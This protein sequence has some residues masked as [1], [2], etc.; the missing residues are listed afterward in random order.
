MSFF[1]GIGTAPWIVQ[2]LV[3]TPRLAFAWEV[4]ADCVAV[5][6]V[7][8]PFVRHRGDA[9][10]DDYTELAELI[11]DEA[12][13]DSLFILV[14]SG[15]P[16][17]DFSQVQNRKEGRLGEE[18][19][20]FS[21][22]CKILQGLEA[23]LGR[24]TFF[25]LAENVVMADDSDTKYFSEALQSQ[26]VL[27]DAADA[28]LISRPRLWWTRVDWSKAKM[29]P[30]T[31]Q[32]LQWTQHNQHRRLRL[33]LPATDTT[34]WD[35]DGHAL[36]T[37]VLQH[38]RRVPCLTTPAPDEHGRA[39]P[40][41]SHGRVDHDTRQRWLQHNRQ[42]APWQYAE[43][44]MAL[45]NDQLVPMPALLKEQLH[46]YPAH[47]T[48]VSKVTNKA[49]HRTLANSWHV[50]VG[51]FIMALVLQV[52]PVHAHPAAGMLT[53]SSAIHQ[54][55]SLGCPAMAVVGPGQWPSPGTAFH[56][57]TTMMEHWTTAL[58]TPHPAQTAGKLEPGLEATLCRH[59]THWQDLQLLRQEVVGEVRCMVDAW[60]PTTQHWFR[61]LPPEIQGVYSANGTKLV[62]Q[63]PLL[64]H[65]LRICGFEGV[66]ELEEDLTCGFPMVGQLHSGSGWLPRRDGQYSHP[67]S[68]SQFHE[69]NRAYVKEKIRQ[70]KHSPHWK[71]ML[72]ELL[73]DKAKGRVQGP[74]SA[75]ASWGMQT[76]GVDGHPCTPTPTSE[77]YPALCFAVEQ[78]DKIRRCEDFRRSSHNSTISV[79]DCPHH[80]DLDLYVRLLQ[81]LKRYDSGTP[82]IWG[83]DLDAAYRQLPVRP[84]AYCYTL[85]V[86]D[87]GVTLAPH[88]GALWSSCS[89]L[90]FQPFC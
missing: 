82:L 71:T 72:D 5:S 70:P 32:P 41:H 57:A 46:S 30:F 45:R 59:H 23:A 13:A 54:V 74:F 18:G 81:R 17:P 53:G 76:V 3:G 10:K 24:H 9:L 58:H 62:T 34:H 75:P 43:H 61:Q 50:L 26:P 27:I 42:Y 83:Q 64:I 49:R 44:A 25:L 20:K 33:G 29:H 73:R 2:Q 1:D 36:H 60:Q 67:I 77:V 7:R 69:L 12:A 11:N 14:T 4:D 40:K 66:D 80:H 35:M 79:D 16:C 15:A 65:L 8:T 28:G 39:P 38:R 56:P 86:V 84:D 90:G 63:V 19:S 52:Q 87:T 68:M 31:G 22:F 78:A 37:D 48:R 89:S 6:K 55:L 85:L 51:A 21:S 47:Y 88:S